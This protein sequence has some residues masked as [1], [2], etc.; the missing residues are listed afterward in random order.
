MYQKQPTRRSSFRDS[1]KTLEADIQ[2]ANSLVAALPQDFSGQCFQM[3]LSYSPFA[4][5]ILFLIEWMGYRCTDTLP[6]SLGL[7]HILVFKTYVDGF[8]ALSSKER[9]ATLPVIYPSL[10]Q[11]KGE[12][13][14]LDN[15]NKP[16]GRKGS[17]GTLTV[18]EAESVR[19]E[20][21]GICFESFTKMVLP[22]CG[23]SLCISCFHDWNPRSKSC[24]FCRASLRSVSCEDLWVLIGHKDVLDT[25]SLARESLSR[26]HLYMDSLPPAVPDMQP[27]L[28]D[29]ML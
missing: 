23:H 16:R 4:P 2:H 21:C 3:K 18:Q 20:E 14:E 9:K 22:N 8:P 26:F 29:Y 12:F 15:G 13:I 28:L 6:T 19:D 25:S 27:F 5:F 1:L 24:P 7:L 10:R 17:D 11:L